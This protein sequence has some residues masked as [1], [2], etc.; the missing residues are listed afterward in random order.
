LSSYQIRSIENQMKLPFWST[1]HP[2]TTA[3]TSL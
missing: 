2:P 1:S 3:K